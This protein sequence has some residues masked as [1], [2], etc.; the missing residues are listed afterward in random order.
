MPR[1]KRTLKKGKTSRK[2]VRRDVDPVDPARSSNTS[3]DL[4]VD[5]RHRNWFFTYNNPGDPVDPV[6]VTWIKDTSRRYAMQLEMGEEKQTPHLQGVV[7]FGFSMRFSVL[8]NVNSEVH[9]EACKS[10]KKAIAYCT[11]VNTRAGPIWSSGFDI[12]EPVI[13]P[14]NEKDFYPWQKD[15]L[16]LVKTKPD[17]RSIYWYW[18][19]EGNVG[20]TALAKHICLKMKGLYIHGKVTDCLYGVAQWVQKRKLEVVIMGIPREYEQ[21]VNYSALEKIKDGIFYS[22]KY[23]SG[24][25]IYNPPHVIVFANFPPLTSKLSTDRWEIRSINNR[26]LQVEEVEAEEV[27]RSKTPSLGARESIWDEMGIDFKRKLA[28]KAPLERQDATIIINSSD[29]DEDFEKKT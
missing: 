8:K 29:E 22:S 17:D 21:F 1:K 28:M 16:E 5:P 10:V 25:V 26:T 7:C 12:P 19:P 4:A 27:G 13:D 18:E 6:F 24:M 3:M 9:W 23:E 2:R 15:V 14:L 20:K 11:K